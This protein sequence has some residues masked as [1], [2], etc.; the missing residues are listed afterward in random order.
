[1]GL[2]DYIGRFQGR[3]TVV[4]RLQ[5]GKGSQPAERAEEN[6]TLSTPW[7]SLIPQPRLE[8]TLLS[9]GHQKFALCFDARWKR[10]RLPRRRALEARMDLQNQL[11]LDR[12][13]QMTGEDNPNLFGTAG[14]QALPGIL[15]GDRA[16]DLDT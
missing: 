9:R 7:S 10:K 8:H 5:A 6:G 11:P 2:H 12:F 1:M 15:D 14:K 16:H 13:V 3:L 4:Y